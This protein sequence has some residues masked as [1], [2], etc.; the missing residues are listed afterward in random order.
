MGAG[1]TADTVA[2]VVRKAE[3]D[4]ALLV[5]LLVT[6]GADAAVVMFMLTCMQGIRQSQTIRN[7]RTRRLMRDLTHGSTGSS[8]SG[9][10]QVQCPR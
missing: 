7:L 5:L 10:M 3:D 2:V 6:M 4:E 9:S 1:A 8:Y